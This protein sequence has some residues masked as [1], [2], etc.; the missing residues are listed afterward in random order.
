MMMI[1]FDEVELDKEEREIEE[2]FERGEWQS[3]ENLDAEIKR[4]QNYAR[5]FTKC[6]TTDADGKH[7]STHAAEPVSRHS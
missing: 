7:L 6:A 3:V 4:Y 1:D 2:S 5:S